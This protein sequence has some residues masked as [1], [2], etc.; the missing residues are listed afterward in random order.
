MSLSKIEFIR[1]EILK[2]SHIST[3]DFSYFY[4]KFS[5]KFHI[6]RGGSLNK[7]ETI[8]RDI[9]KC[10]K[11]VEKDGGF[12]IEKRPKLW[13][14]IYSS[15]R[16]SDGNIFEGNYDLQKKYENTFG[17][18]GSIRCEVCKRLI[19][20]ATYVYINYVGNNLGNFF[21]K[22]TDSVNPKCNERF[23]LVGSFFN[24]NSGH[25]LMNDLEPKKM[26]DMLTSIDCITTYTKSLVSNKINFNYSKHESDFF[27]KFILANIY[28]IEIL[29]KNN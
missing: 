14:I 12:V 5:N 6:K 22:T 2:K 8:V 17:S 4:G 29:K 13:V 27:T 9:K 15:N 1:S 21:S 24:R 28:I 20:N 7:K 18:Y 11:I 23:D 10:L 26:N 25:L 3:S 19:E 16:L